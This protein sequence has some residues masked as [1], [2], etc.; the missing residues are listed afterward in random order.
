MH[1]PAKFRENTAKN[2]FLSY[3][4]KTKRDGQTDGRRCNILSLPGPTAPAVDTK[5][6]LGKARAQEQAQ[7]GNTINWWGLL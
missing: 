2:A 6:A 3:S 1:V 7:R 5:E 4:A